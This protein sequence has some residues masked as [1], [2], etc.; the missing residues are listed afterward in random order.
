M[1][2]TWEQKTR[3]IQIVNLRQPGASLDFLGFTFRYKRDLKGRGF[4]YLNVTPLA[5][6]LQAQ[7]EALRKMI[8][9]RQSHVSVPHLIVSVNGQLR[10]W[11]NYFSFQEVGADL[12]RKKAS[13]WDKGA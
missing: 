13:P 2:S 3:E 10:G 6:A 8:G 7:R 5:K 12:D 11:A 1:K 4:R 9:N